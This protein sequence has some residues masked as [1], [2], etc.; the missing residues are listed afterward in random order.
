MTNIYSKYKDSGLE[1]VGCIPNHWNIK[2]FRYLS[3]VSKDRN[4]DEN[5]RQMLAV[6][7]YYGIIPKKYEVENQKRS[8]ADSLNY[9][10]VNKNQ[11]V[12]N[13][14]WLNYGGIGVSKHDGIVSPAYRVYSLND[15]VIPRFIHYL[16]R[17]EIYID[18]YTR[19][20]YGIRPNSLQVSVEDFG[21][22]PTLIP[23]IP[24]QQSI[25]DFLDLRTRQIDKFI[26]KRLNQIE[27]IKEYR[28]VLINNAVTKGLNPDSPTKDTGID[29]LGKI[30]HHWNVSRVKYEF[31]S[32]DNMRIPLSAEV[33]GTMEN[34]IYDYYGA[35]GVI[36][37]VD[38]YIFDETLILLGED[39]ANL[40]LR[41]KPLAFLAKGK[42]WVN[43][44]AHV[45]K[46]KQ[47]NIEYLVNL[48][49]AVDYQPYVTGSAQPKLTADNLRN[50]KIPIPPIQEQNLIANAL[51]EISTKT[52]KE[53]SQ[54]NK[55]INLLREYRMTLISES[56]SGK[57]DV[58]GI[59]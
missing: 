36:D 34:K 12:L 54:L 26:Q 53:I 47:G 32:L 55:Q 9:L 21:N 59:N 6:S 17:S 20:M 23:T 52:N 11:L 27:L 5:D 24:E 39:G 16:F 37:K 38:D 30:P 44:H 49:E 3:S 10:I 50:V 56:V 15:E 7:Q 40:I 58:R 22:L 4:D 51:S 48:L 35:S 19:L 46:P 42:Y 41:S 33:R 43:N 13:T 31:E 28:K 45:L 1:W 14:M 25:A 2:R 18:E 8:K 29:W 57:I